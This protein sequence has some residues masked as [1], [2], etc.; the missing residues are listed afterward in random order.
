MIQIQVYLMVQTFI[1]KKLFF[2]QDKVEKKYGENG[3]FCDV[4]QCFLFFSILMIQQG[5]ICRSPQKLP[6]SFHHVCLWHTQL[7]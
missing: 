1:N 5:G 3:R 4:S 6:E 7:L 2:K